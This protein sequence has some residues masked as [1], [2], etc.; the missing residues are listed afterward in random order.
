ML[1]LAVT[2]YS[3]TSAR[4]YG[5]QRVWVLDVPGAQIREGGQ[6]GTVNVQLS[7]SAL[8]YYTGGN[9]PDDLLDLIAWWVQDLQGNPRRV[10]LAFD[11]FGGRL[12]YERIAQALDRGDVV[13]SSEKKNI[14]TDVPVGG[15]AF[16]FYLGS[17]N[18]DTFIRIYNKAA[19]MLASGEVPE[20]EN[21][22]R[23]EVELKRKRAAKLFSEWIEQGYARDYAAGILRGALDFRTQTDDKT[24]TRWPVKAWWQAFIGDVQ[25]VK[26]TIEGVVT[27][28]QE[29]VEWVATQVAPTLAMIED[30][31][32]VDFIGAIVGGGRERLTD[33]DRSLVRV[34]LEMLGDRD[35][36]TIGSSDGRW[37]SDPDPTTGAAKERR[38]RA[39][40]A[41]QE[42]I[43]ERDLLNQ[44]WAALEAQGV[45][46]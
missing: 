5:Y 18:S 40:G 28:L 43:Q 41:L 45:P 1:G 9:C 26:V 17:R 2:D 29:K 13:R 19:Q 22:V 36:P 10:D 23:C 38:R 46:V 25:A 30:A 32:G 8:E 15:E 33:A 21:W 7:A 34:T 37:A 31:F 42:R 24:V 27:T 12:T 4:P 11:D 35:P 44:L 14:V 39:I 6:N 20:H 16:T 3:L